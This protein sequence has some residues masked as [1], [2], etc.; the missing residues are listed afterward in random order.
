MS[1]WE[2]TEGGGAWTSS[3]EVPA[4]ARGGSGVFA[5]RA[6]G[7][8]WTES[9]SRQPVRS[10]RSTTTTSPL[11]PQAR[12]S[13]AEVSVSRKGCSSTGGASG[14]E[15][16]SAS[17]SRSTRCLPSTR[18]R[19]SSREPSRRCVCAASHAWGCTAATA[20]SRAAASLL[21]RLRSCSSNHA[22]MARCSPESGDS[23]GVRGRACS[24]P[25]GTGRARAPGR[26]PAR[27][28][29]AALGPARCRPRRAIPLA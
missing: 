12:R 22:C 21:R 15:P 27:G 1:G 29:G 6:G 8:G 11:Q 20:S 17:D 5:T 28:G 14:P 23:G 26:A 3:E 18:R 19:S 4:R 13:S 9:S 16:G 10:R 24:P 25:G 2:G 7:A